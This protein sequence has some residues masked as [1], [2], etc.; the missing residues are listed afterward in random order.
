MPS[1]RSFARAVLTTAITSAVVLGG[2]A[3]YAAD[4]PTDTPVDVAAPA[5]SG[6]VAAPATVDASTAAVPVVVYAHA[7]DPAGVAHLSVALGGDPVALDLVAG[8]ATSGEWSGTVTVPAFTGHGPLAAQVSA[9][10]ALGN[11]AGTAVDAAVTVADAPPAAPA[12]ASVTLDTD[13][14][15]LHVAWT[16]PA[17]NGGSGVTGY[18]VAVE[19][20]VTDAGHPATATTDADTQHATVTGLDPATRYV[21]RVTARNAAGTSP[22]AIVDATTAA[23]PTTPSA[24]AAVT[25]TPEDS[26]LDVQ[27]STPRSDGGSTLTGYQVHVTSGTGALD[28][29]TV[30]AT[31]TSAIVPGLV[32]GETYAVTVAGVNALGTGLTAA[33][34]ATPRTVP[35]APAI[36]TVTAGDAS[37]V[38]HWTAPTSDGGSSLTGYLVTAYPAGTVHVVPANATSATVTGLRNGVATTFTV[39]AVNAAGVGT[40]SAKSATVTP[41]KVVVIRIAAQPAEHV[42]YGSA[43]SVRASVRTAGG[44]LLP[45]I[46]VDLYARTRPA[47]T[48]H[49]VATGKTASTGYVTLRATLPATSALRLQHTA[50]ALV[51]SA[52]SVRSVWVATRVSAAASATHVSLGQTVAVH[53]SI[54]PAHPAG[55]TV[56]LQRHTSTGWHTVANGRMDTTTTYHVSWQPGTSG[57]WYLRVVKPADTDHEQ[58]ASTSWRQYVTETVAEVAAQIRANSRITLDKVHSSGVT[59]LAVASGDLMDLAYGHWAHR[60]SYGTAP[61]GS[62][63]VDIRLLRALRAIGQKGA[64]TVSEVAGGTHAA[65]SAHYAGKAMDIRIVNGVHVAPGSS[66]GWVVDTCRAYGATHLYY[67]A[68]DPV[69]GHSNHVHCDWS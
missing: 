59:D 27:W 23:V 44:T 69:G 21:V 10:D 17:A 22:A 68:Y 65:G 56:S 13:P 35:A 33:A 53:G 38:L 9:V 30:P 20:E 57:A 50:D 28:P 60:S 40:A 5:V 51:G 47:T 52:V 3:A 66:Y 37:A 49:R 64:V 55:S 25:V 18:D 1:S 14:G 12:Q 24:P 41:R 39:A 36:G 62:T 63:P 61:G 2:S 48:W 32:N 29:F 6:L 19:S 43:S 11:S 26:A 67:P 16:P 4:V 15:T 46:P 8:D 42:R 45:G 31:A 34:Q 54:A 58:G 7:A